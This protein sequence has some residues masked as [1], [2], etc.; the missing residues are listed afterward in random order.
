MRRGQ[1]AVS[2][3]SQKVPALIGMGWDFIRRIGVKSDGINVAIY[4]GDAGRLQV[5]AGPR[6]LAPFAGSGDVVCA[7]TPSGKVATVAHIGPY[8]RLGEAH[9]AIREFCAAH[10]HRLEGTNWEIYG[11]WTD[12]ASRLRTDVY[13]LLRPVVASDA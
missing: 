11:H 5:E 7:T 4:R 6:V 3:L 13:Y 2:E 9:N 8:H 12:D 10:G 1:A